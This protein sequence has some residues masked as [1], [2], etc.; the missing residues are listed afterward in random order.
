[1]RFLAG[2]AHRGRRAEA[3]L[4]GI[5]KA[6][7]GE[8]EQLADLILEGWLALANDFSSGTY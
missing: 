7:A 4:E 5:D 6:V 8:P 2:H 1:L 3:Y